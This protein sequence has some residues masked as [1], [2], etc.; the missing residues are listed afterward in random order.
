MDN[1]GTVIIID[2][3]T[4]NGKYLY[5][6]CKE[7]LPGADV[8]WLLVCAPGKE[9]ILPDDMT[10]FVAPSLGGAARFIDGRV[11]E[12]EAVLVFYNPQLGMLQRNVPTA[13]DSQV[14]QALRRMVEDGRRILV[15]VHSTDMPTREIAEFLDP[16]FV[17]NPS[18]SRVIS[19]HLI[20]GSSPGAVKAVVEETV[21]EWEK[22]FAVGRG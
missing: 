1:T 7:L 21:G 11:K 22:R 4:A 20:T 9:P 3:N 2:N 5:R 8:C 19:H 17:S 13:V 14:T 16:S 15:N 12:G 18:E 6:F 10:Y